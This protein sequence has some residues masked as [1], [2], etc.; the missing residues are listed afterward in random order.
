MEELER[1]FSRQGFTQG[2]Y[3][4]QKGQEMFGT[5]QEGE[6]AKELFAAARATY[7]NGEAQLVRAFLRDAASGAARAAGRAG[8]PRQC[9]QDG[10]AGAGAGG[11]SRAD[12]RGSREPP[13]QD[14]R[15]AISLRV[16][17]DGGSAE[18]CSCPLR[19]S[20]RCGAM[21]LA[22]LTAQRGR[23]KP[24]RLHPL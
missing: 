3:L 5:R 23:V 11:L 9:V 7:E 18:T 10:R 15:N 4:G 8:R 14:R 19:P 21:W 24:A 22:Q 12:A 6:D 20:T 2:Y 13:G 16:G 1:V 17:E